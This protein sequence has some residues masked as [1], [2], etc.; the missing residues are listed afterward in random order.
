[1]PD[2]NT[3]YTFAEGTTNGAFVVTPHGESPQTISIHGLKSAAFTDSSEYDRAGSA[4]AVL[5]TSGDD[6]SV[7]TVYGAIAAAN[8]ALGMANDAMPK[9]GGDFTGYVSNA[10]APT[11]DKHLANK[12]YVDDQI[13]ANVASVFK[14][15]GT[16]DTFAELPQSGATEGDV[17][18]VT[19]KHTEY[20]YAKV[21]GSS[22]YTWEELGG[23]VDLTEYVTKSELQG[24]DYATKTEVSTAKSEAIS[25][26]STDATNKVSTAKNEIIGTS[27]DS[28]S[29]N[30][31]YGAKKK[32]TEEINKLANIAKTGN[33]TDLIQ[34]A[35]DILIFDCGTSSTIM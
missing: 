31:I 16:K 28:S 24:K 7:K 23:V 1:M 33:V 19:E 2:N 30:T 14:F 29:T 34:S 15:K 22:S 11:M 18:H 8:E 35:S 5:G 10:S 9:S 27:G 26:A 3:T 32:I 20:V 25:T 12:K 13:K 21:D 6:K 17:W 4:S